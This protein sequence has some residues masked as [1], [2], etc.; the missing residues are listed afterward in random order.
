M[1]LECDK[2]ETVTTDRAILEQVSSRRS[3][4]GWMVLS[5][6]ERPLGAS[7]SKIQSTWQNIFLNQPIFLTKIQLAASTLGASLLVKV[8]LSVTTYNQNHINR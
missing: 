2:Q 5:H 1:I 4:F 7:S 8:H 6:D 3:I